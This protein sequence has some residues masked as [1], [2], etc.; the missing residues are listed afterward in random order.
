MQTFARSDPDVRGRWL[1]SPPFA[2]AARSGRELFGVAW[3]G[4]HDLGAR[5]TAEGVVDRVSVAG[6]VPAHTRF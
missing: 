5:L 6:L 1:I 3:G 2:L 4:L